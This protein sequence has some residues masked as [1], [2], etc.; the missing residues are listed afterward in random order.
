[1]RRERAVKQGK[2]E[3]KAKDDDFLTPLCSKSLLQLL[4][5]KAINRYLSS[6]VATVLVLALAVAVR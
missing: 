3:R 4:A 5:S 1:M 6:P 2:E